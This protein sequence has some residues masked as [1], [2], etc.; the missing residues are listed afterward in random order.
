MCGQFNR[1]TNELSGIAFRMLFVNQQTGNSAQESRFK[2]GL[3]SVQQY[4]QY[5]LHWNAVLHIIS[6]RNVLVKER[7]KT[8][9]YK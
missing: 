5:T 3:L 7:N 9:T 6:K 2:R 1:R 8:I 4:T